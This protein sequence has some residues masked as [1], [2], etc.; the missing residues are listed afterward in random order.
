MAK[1]T[2]TPTDASKLIR[3]IEGEGR[4]QEVALDIFSPIRI[5]DA[6]LRGKGE[7]K[8]WEVVVIGPDT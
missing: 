4:T 5:S 2:Y 3:L 1:A 7:G 6:Q 8:E